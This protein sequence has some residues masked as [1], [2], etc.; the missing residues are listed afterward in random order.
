M[1]PVIKVTNPYGIDPQVLASARA[2]GQDNPLDIRQDNMMGILMKVLGLPGIAM[3]ARIPSPKSLGGPQPPY[4]PN[5]LKQGVMKLP[6]TKEGAMRMPG[7]RD[8]L[9]TIPPEWATRML[10][11]PGN[12]NIPLDLLPHD[13]LNA[14]G[15]KSAKSPLG[16]VQPN[17]KAIVDKLLG[18]NEGKGNF[19]TNDAMKLKPQANDLSTIQKMELTGPEKMELALQDQ[20]LKQMG[21]NPETMSPMEK[22]MQL[23]PE[24]FKD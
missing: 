3:G 15:M 20:K 14:P 21:F 9:N 12:L 13:F 11:K 6:S 18:P 2:Q 8:N 5:E 7:M 24:L 10:D 1:D 23:F 17:N 19:G 4:N 16:T 22:L